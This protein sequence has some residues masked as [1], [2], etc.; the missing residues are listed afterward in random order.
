MVSGRSKQNWSSLKADNW[1]LNWTTRFQENLCESDGM[2]VRAL[3]IDIYLAG[4][5][6]RVWQVKNTRTIAICYSSHKV[7]KDDQKDCYQHRR[8]GKL[9]K[10]MLDIHNSTSR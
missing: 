9:G 7:N 3:K 10:V 2:H 6:T 4:D 1:T 8:T 5:T